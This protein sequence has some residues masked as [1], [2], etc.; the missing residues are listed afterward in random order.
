MSLTEEQQR[1]VDEALA[2][3][4]KPPGDVIHDGPY[5]QLEIGKLHAQKL[6]TI[7]RELAEAEGPLPHEVRYAQSGTIIARFDLKVEAEQAFNG[8]PGKVTI[9]DRGEAT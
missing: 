6:V 5:S 8:W 4:R 1:R 3:S 7:I 9:R 2:W